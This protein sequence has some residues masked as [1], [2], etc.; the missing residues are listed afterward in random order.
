[1]GALNFATG[2]VANDGVWYTS[3]ARASGKV[4]LATV[5]P[6]NTTSRFN[7]GWDINT[8]GTINDSFYFFSDANIYF[9]SNGGA[10]LI[11]TPYTATT[12]E[13]ALVMRATGMDRYIKGGG[14]TYWTLL[15]VSAA[16][17]AAGIPAINVDSTT[18]I[19]V[20]DDFRVPV[21]TF[22]PVPIQSDGMSAATTDG[23]GHEEANGVSGNAYTNVGTWGVAAGVRSC[24]ALSGGLGFS[25]LSCTS[26]DVLI[27]VNVTRSA[28]NAGGVARY[29]DANNYLIFYIE[30]TN[31]VCAKVVA[32]VQ[33]T[34][35]TGAVTY[36]AGAMLR[37]VLESA[38]SARLFY[39]DLAVVGAKFT[40]PS[41]TS[42]N[43]GLYTTDTGNTFDNLVIRAHGTNN[44]YSGLD[45]L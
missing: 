34:L 3:L 2:A 18:S 16:G 12:Y 21:T 19:F 42:G 40:V 22:V 32:G 13:I 7:I 43:H 24:S 27:D 31:A 8:A 26:G 45:A 44:E 28:G 25:Y 37:L 5:I 17:T 10:S 14:F 6:A 23:L 39:N 11:I 4:L 29:V 41:S 20:V 33:T 36:S 9:R 30:G 15:W 35:R 1:M 38:T